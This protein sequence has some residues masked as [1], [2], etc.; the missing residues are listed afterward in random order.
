[1]L[2]CSSSWREARSSILCLPQ[3][4]RNN[5]R[6]LLRSALISLEPFGHHKARDCLDRRSGSSIRHRYIGSGFM[7]V[8]GWASWKMHGEL[9]ATEADLALGPAPAVARVKT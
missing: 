7:P 5:R 3:G 2:I 6:E 8:G 9:T 1:R 4:N